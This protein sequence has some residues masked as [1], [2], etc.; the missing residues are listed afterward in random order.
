[1]EKDRLWQLRLLLEW[2][3]RFDREDEAVDALEDGEED[4]MGQGDVVEE[5]AGGEVEGEGMG[6]GRFYLAG[7]AG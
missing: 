1:M 5:G 3:D 7:R 6:Y 4:K 2:F